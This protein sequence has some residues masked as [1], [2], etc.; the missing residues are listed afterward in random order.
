MCALRISEKDCKK[1]IGNSSLAQADAKQ[2]ITNKSEKKYS[3]CP[4]LAWQLRQCG[5]PDFRWE[6][7]KDGEYRFHHKRKWRFDFYLSK[8]KVAIEVEGGI[9]TH[10]KG[11]ETTKNG[12]QQVMQSRHLTYDGFDEDAEKYFEAE[13]L[14]VFV[15]RASPRMVRKGI[16]ASMALQALKFRG[17]SPVGPSMAYNAFIG[18]HKA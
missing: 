4:E 15:I 12:T 9:S 10:R 14:G 8:Y 16:A 7:H 11:T 6:G 5:C 18:V 2:K 17:W 3:S 13:L 1:L